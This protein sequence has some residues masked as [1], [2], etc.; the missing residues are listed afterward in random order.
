[1]VAC[2][3]HVRGVLRPELKQQLLASPLIADTWSLTEDSDD[4]DGQTLLFGYPAVSARGAYLR[5]V[6]KVELGARSDVE[7]T[8]TP[9]ITPYVAEALP[10]IC[11]NGS[12]TVRTVAP[13][14]TFWEKVALLHEETYRETAVAPKARLARHYYDIWALIQAGTGDQALADLDLFARVAAHRAV[15]FRKR[16]EA[17]DS[18]RPG[19][20]RV[21]PAADR[22]KAWAEDYEAMRESMFFAE[23]PSFDEILTVVADFERQVNDANK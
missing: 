13:T 23:P 16:Q 2:Q 22:R 4:P 10:T 17:Q 21:V 9:L 11:A 8:A 5:P 7:P 3:H 6:V 14:R 12:F 19:Q 20:L 1:M 15:F 18:L